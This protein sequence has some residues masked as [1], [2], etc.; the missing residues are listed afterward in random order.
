MIP[1][2]TPAITGSIK[3]D[4]LV[5]A[6]TPKKK[7]INNCATEMKTNAIV[8]ILL[9]L[10]NLGLAGYVIYLKNHSRYHQELLQ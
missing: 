8:A 9:L 5:P 3:Y 7:G 1:M 6:T 2:H 4:M 10:N